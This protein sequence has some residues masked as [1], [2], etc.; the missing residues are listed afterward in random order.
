MASPARQRV[1][2]RAFVARLLAA[3]PEAL[4][5]TGLGSP[6]YDAYACG[7]SARYFYLWGAMGGAAPMGLGLALAQ[8]GRPVIVLTGDGEALMGLGS[9]ATIAAQRPANLTVVVLDNGHY[10]ETGMQKSHTSLGTDLVAV[11]RGCGLRESFAVDRLEAADEIARRVNSRQG[12]ALVQV[13]IEADEP[14]RALPSRD[15]VHVK[16]RLRAELGLAPF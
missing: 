2:R 7:D 5:V 6:T 11:A 4:V 8:P 15:G 14:P 12:A 3:T 1:D 16:N 9:L 10:G 13:S